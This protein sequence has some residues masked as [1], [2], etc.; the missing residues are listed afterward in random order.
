MEHFDIEDMFGRR[1]KPGLELVT[2]LR[3]GGTITSSGVKSYWCKI[4]VSL[5]NTGRGIAKYCD[6][7]IGV[8]KPYEILRDGEGTLVPLRSNKQG[9]AKFG[10]NADIVIHPDTVVQV[11]SLRVTVPESSPDQVI[12]DAAIKYAINAEDMRRIEDTRI[13][14]AADVIQVALSQKTT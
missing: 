12:P 13:I 9:Y 3:R 8:N 10:A 2:E 14:K 4:L 6:L 7:H 5:Q 11:I 1:K